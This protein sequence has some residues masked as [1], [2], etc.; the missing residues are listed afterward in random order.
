MR[1]FPTVHCDAER[2]CFTQ[3]IK[4]HCNGAGGTSDLRSIQHRAILLFA[5]LFLTPV[6]RGAVASR[7]GPRGHSVCMILA[8][9]ARERCG[10][11]RCTGGASSRA[12]RALSNESCAPDTF[13][14]HS[15]LP[16]I[17]GNAKNYANSKCPSAREARP[18]LFLSALFGPQW[19]GRCALHRGLFGRAKRARR[20]RKDNGVPDTTFRKDEDQDATMRI[21]AL[22]RTCYFFF[23]SLQP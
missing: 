20:T 1:A 18:S 6:A 8:S 11:I 9:V 5:R 7:R 19:T 16:G 4:S 22:N 12:A 13:Q 23:S 17:G 2:E 3:L 21:I 14:S 10:K 15:P